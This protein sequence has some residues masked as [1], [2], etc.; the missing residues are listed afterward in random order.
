MSQLNEI[1]PFIESLKQFNLRITR[2]RIRVLEILNEVQHAMTA[3]EIE[4]F[5]L[6]SGQHVKIGS[7]YMILKA[8]QDIGIVKCYKL[9]NNKALYSLSKLH[10]PNK[11]ECIGCGSIKWI[12]L[13]EMNGFL[14]AVCIKHGFKFKAHSLAVSA[15]CESCQY[16]KNLNKKVRRH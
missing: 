3:F 8:F 12:D 16:H 9:E 1:Q 15:I 7:I 10:S 14:E 6:T 13:S 11:I 2:H 5:S 4:H